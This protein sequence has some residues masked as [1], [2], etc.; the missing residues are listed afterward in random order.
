MIDIVI[1]VCD[2]KTLSECVD[3]RPTPEMI[4]P[5]PE[6]QKYFSQMVPALQQYMIS[7][8]PDV[9]ND[10]EEMDIKKTLKEAKFYQVGSDIKFFFIHRLL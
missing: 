6:M 5:C 9:Y 2:V 4:L 7:K 8:H 3:L 10:L 1:E